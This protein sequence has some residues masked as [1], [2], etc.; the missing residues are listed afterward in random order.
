MRRGVLVAAILSLAIALC[1]C[2]G[3]GA[4]GAESA[5]G[6]Y[7]EGLNALYAELEDEDVDQAP[8]D[9]DASFAEAAD[10]FDG[11][12]EIDPDHC[13]AL[14][15]SALTHVLLVATDPD[16][17]E[18]MRELFPDGGGP[19]PRSLFWY[20]RTPAVTA[21]LDALADARGELHLSELQEY[22]E[23]TALSEL[24]VADER[25]TRFE[26]LDCEVD[27][28]I[29]V[30]G[31]GTEDRQLVT[32]ELD[33]TDAYLAHAA[34]DALQCA[35]RCIASYNVD[36]DEGQTPEHLVESDADFLTLRY[37]DHLPAAHAELAALGLNLESAGQSLLEETDPQG[38]DLVTENE[39]LVRLDEV[40]G[41]SS[42]ERVREMGESIGAALDEGVDVELR[43]LDESAP[44][45]VVHLD[46]GELLN[47]PLE[48]M[49]DYL[50]EH[51]W[52]TPDTMSVTLPLRM[53]DPTLDGITPDMSEAE[54]EPVVLWVLGR[55]TRQ[56]G[57][58]TLQS[59][60]AVFR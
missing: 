51:T 37:G 9:W 30:P 45:V 7:L 49:R 44:D 40:L 1:G 47:D 56:A 50:P 38:N 60:R 57:V 23:S 24:E 43:E 48:D 27:L 31:E 55:A 21:A 58:R 29:D 36:M 2:G 19:R 34:L 54:W 8:W 39:G 42:G 4:T 33:V 25:L 26:S 15:G 11:A 12:L 41:E 17:A 28:I 32:I 3:D 6:L 5:G 10:K 35:C 59:L 13:G 20:A 52:P 53:P 46:I 16:L 22:I 14:L 18:I